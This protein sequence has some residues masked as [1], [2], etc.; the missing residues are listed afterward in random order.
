MKGIEEEKSGGV[1]EMDEVRNE[2]KRGVEKTGYIEDIVTATQN[3]VK[4]NQ[5]MNPKK[6]QNCIRVSLEM[7]KILVI[8]VVHIAPRAKRIYSVFL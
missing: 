4:K 5:G 3:E 2:K 8:E 1:E 6:S 7:M